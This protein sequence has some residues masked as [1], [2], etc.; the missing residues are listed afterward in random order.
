VHDRDTVLFGEGFGF[1]GVAGCDGGDDD[2]GVRFR[3]DYECQGAVFTLV[4]RGDEMRLSGYARNG[5]GAENTDAN[6]IILLWRSN[7]R[8]EK[9][10]QPLSKTVDTCHCVYGRIVEEAF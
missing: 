7:G 3:G 5:R 9:V 2:F 6:G 4:F 8:V 1:L 10:V